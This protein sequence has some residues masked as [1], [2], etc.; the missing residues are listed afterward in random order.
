MINSN[1]LKKIMADNLKSLLSSKGITQTMM[2]K[3]LDIPEMTVSNWIKGKTYPRPDKIQLMAN[4]FGVNRSRLTEELPENVDVFSQS[5]TIAIPVLGKI[6]CGDPILAEQNISRYIYESSELLPSGELAYLQANGDSMAPTIPNKAMVVIR[7][8]P[9]VESGE[10]AAVLLNGD[11]EATLKRVKKQG[12]TLLLVPD[13]P[14][15]DPIIVNEE[16]PARIIGKAVKL[17]MTL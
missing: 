3:D 15:Y 10:I 5:S 17:S 2:A 12:N 9:D 13:N 11:S 1:S 4:Y 6:A 14:A 7:L 16:N 8:Q